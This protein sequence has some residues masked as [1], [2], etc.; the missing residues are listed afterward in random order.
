[1][2]ISGRQFSHLQELLDYLNGIVL[3]NALKATL[4]LHSLTLIIDN[5]KGHT[6]TFAGN[7]LPPNQ[8]ADQINAVVEGAVVLRT[9]GH[10]T[11]PQPHLAFIQ[12]SLRIKT[13]GTA[14]ARLGLPTAG[15]DLVVGT[16][17]VTKEKIISIT[18][19]PNRFTVV[20]E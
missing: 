3:S 16:T 11:P 10:H 14:N 7:S 1:V 8:V 19:T 12:N 13:T 5:G 17:A 2:A 4:N 6:I 18:E 15:D 9:Y 20:H